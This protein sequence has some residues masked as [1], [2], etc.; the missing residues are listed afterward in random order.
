[1]M[2]QSTLTNELLPRGAPRTTAIVETASPVREKI[3]NLN[4]FFAAA[5]T[6]T[7][8]EFLALSESSSAGAARL[9]HTK[10]HIDSLRRRK[11]S[12]AIG[13]LVFLAVSIAVHVLAIADG[14]IGLITAQPVYVREILKWS[15]PVTNCFEETAEK[16]GPCT[17]RCDWLFLLLNNCSGL[18]AEHNLTQCVHAC[19]LTDPSVSDGTSVLLSEA[20]DFLLLASEL[21]IASACVF[22][23]AAVLQLVAAF[24]RLRRPGVARFVSTQLSSM[25]TAI[26]LAAVY[27]FSQ[28]NVPATRPA[29][30]FMTQTAVSSAW[31]L[32][33]KPF[34]GALK[35]SW[36]LLRDRRNCPRCCWRAAQREALNLASAEG[37]AALYQA[38]RPIQLGAIINAPCIGTGIACGQLLMCL[39]AP[40]ERIGL[41]YSVLAVL[42]LVALDIETALVTRAYKASRKAAQQHRQPE[43]ARGL[44]SRVRAAYIALPRLYAG[45]GVFL[46]LAV[47]VC[48]YVVVRFFFS[49]DDYH[50][51]FA[52]LLRGFALPF[53]VSPF[54]TL[55][56]LV[57]SGTHHRPARAVLVADSIK[58]LLMTIDS[59]DLLDLV[60]DLIDDFCD[61]PKAGQL[62]PDCELSHHHHA[63]PGLLVIQRIAIVCGVLAA[64]MLLFVVI[65]PV[66]RPLPHGGRA[67]DF[68]NHTLDEMTDEEALRRYWFKRCSCRR[69][70]RGRAESRDPRGLPPQH[71]DRRVT[72]FAVVALLQL[73]LVEVPAL[74]V[75][76]VIAAYTYDLSPL[77]IKN[78]IGIAESLE[79]IVHSRHEP[80]PALIVSA[81]GTTPSPDAHV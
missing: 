36:E 29:A 46:P 65:A 73:V 80:R 1:M 70:G 28:S 16:L 43:S 47:I 72:R 3:R 5:R 25:S 81:L 54:V 15:E 41:V 49:F 79:A 17:E 14:P 75:R 52:W 50:G 67:S 58:L 30:V 4:E 48:L 32:G 62:S 59:L 63:S 24:A 13:V 44:A 27:M 19:S 45:V 61:D 76:A 56:D 39:I 35:N 20:Y 40:A 31:A 57:R 42:G 69:Q 6:K 38:S 74:V 68:R 55:I 7:I 78:V 71:A 22:F 77:V 10:Q 12:A 23:A 26:S 34:F 9:E 11:W 21:S 64:L 37:R 18:A 60:R 2:P 66:I 33:A 53:M 8:A 51:E